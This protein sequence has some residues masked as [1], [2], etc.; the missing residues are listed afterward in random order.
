MPS[1]FSFS[2]TSMILLLL[3][4]SFALSSTIN[5]K[6]HIT[7]RI[8]MNSDNAASNKNN[9]YSDMD[10]LNMES[11]VVDQVTKE[12]NIDKDDTNMMTGGPMGTAFS[13]KKMSGNDALQ[14]LKSKEEN[15]AKNS[16]NQ[17]SSSSDDEKNHSF[18]YG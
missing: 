16:G 1:D 10:N 17:M 12:N 14:S 13:A 3:F 9:D 7:K 18:V 8:L 5:T 4:T 2:L 15:V 6:N 11:A